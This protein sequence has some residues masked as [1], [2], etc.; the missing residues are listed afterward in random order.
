M[1]HDGVM[2]L[3]EEELSDLMSSGMSAVVAMAAGWIADRVWGIW[4]SRNSS[5]SS[6]EGMGVRHCSADSEPF[7]TWTKCNA[8]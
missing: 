5:R 1:V 3:S 6:A 8:A 2:R 7:F 4:R